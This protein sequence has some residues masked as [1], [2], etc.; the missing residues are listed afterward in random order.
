MNVAVIDLGFG[1]SGKG[2]VVDWLSH[3]DEDFE[4]VIRYT[5]AHQSTHAVYLNGRYH[6]F[7]NF[8]S[9]TFR[10]LPTY[11]H[12]RV[13]VSPVK[14]CIEEQVLLEKF[15]IQPVL[16][17]HPDCQITTPYDVEA[18]LM[19]ANL[20]TVGEGIKETFQRVEKL[21]L[22]LQMKDLFYPSV[23]QMKFYQIEDY[24]K[25]T[26]VNVDKIYLDEFKRACTYCIPFITDAS[27]YCEEFAIYESTQGLLLDEQIGFNPYV[28]WGKLGSD[29]IKDSL[30]EVYYVTRAY[31]TRHGNGPIGVKL[32]ND[33]IRENIYETNKSNNLQGHLRSNILDLDLLTYAYN[34][35]SRKLDEDITKNLVVTCCD[36]VKEFKVL[37][38]GEVRPFNNRN[39]FLEHLYGTLD[40]NNIYFSEAPEGE[41]NLY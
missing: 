8:G 31:H 26:G 2:R 40:V 6:Q 7:Q 27:D 38:E 24:Y 34:I 3:S 11:W 29:H 20:D 12:K 33:H 5:G 28:S 14:I 37:E 25:Q 30:R 32:I 15:N 13:P 17:I 4:S 39:E 1:D 36:I 10:D 41:I 18:N 35:D 9:G 21:N 23:F 22:S 16:Y 19:R